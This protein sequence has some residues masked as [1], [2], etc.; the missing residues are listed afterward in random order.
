MGK[1]LFHHGDNEDDD[2]DV[3]D[4]TRTD[5]AQEWARPREGLDGRTVV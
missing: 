1:L 4:D 5:I 3:D 2:N